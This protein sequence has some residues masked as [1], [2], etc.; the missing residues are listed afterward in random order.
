M[1]EQRHHMKSEA[2]MDNMWLRGVNLAEFLSISFE[3]KCAS[4]R[5]P[6]VSGFV[7]SH[8]VLCMCDLR[9]PFIILDKPLEAAHNLVTQ[10]P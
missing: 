5:R 1:E 2:L 3:V 8:I 9:Y 10:A 4:A 7:L 6:Q